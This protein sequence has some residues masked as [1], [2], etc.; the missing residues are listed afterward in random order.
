[1]R[2]IKECPKCGNNAWILS[3][4]PDFTFELY[5]KCSKC[6]CEDVF[7]LGKFM[8]QSEERRTLLLGCLR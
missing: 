8:K 1:M 2:K 6:G 7:I 3:I 4:N 5:L